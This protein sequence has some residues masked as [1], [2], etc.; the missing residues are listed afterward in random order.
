MG[1]RVGQDRK[2]VGKMRKRRECGSQMA[3]M[4]GKSKRMERH[5]KGQMR[6]KVYCMPP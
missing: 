5:D 6:E 2:M 1:G 4:G 3:E